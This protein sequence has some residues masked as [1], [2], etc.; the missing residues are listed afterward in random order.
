MRDASGWRRS[1]PEPAVGQVARAAL[2][3][4]LQRD[5]A[6]AVSELR[7]DLGAR[8]DEVFGG[9]SQR[10]DG[11]RLAPEPPPEAPAQLRSQL[12][13]AYRELCRRLEY[14]DGLVDIPR[15]FDKVRQRMPTLGV[16]T[17]H[18]ELAQLWDA[19]QL[20]LR[21]VNEVHELS[22]EQ[23]ALGIRRDNA[24]HYYVYWPL[25]RS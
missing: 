19:D 9:L 5:L 15:L 11:L 16:A 24:L 3:H 23:R 14:E 20:Q 18:E 22:E 21:I 6:T 2:L 12:A 1:R 4:E 7:A 25:E 10:L 13:W 8:I 17:L